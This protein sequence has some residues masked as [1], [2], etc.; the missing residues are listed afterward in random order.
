MKPAYGV[1]EDILAGLYGRAAV[2][3]RDVQARISEIAATVNL[4]WIERAIGCF[5]E[6][7]LMVRRNIQKV[8]AL[9]AMIINLRNMA[10]PV[11]A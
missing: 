5:D 9:D 11:S 10:K 1:L 7:V 8:G 4:R 3:N 6:F 2:K